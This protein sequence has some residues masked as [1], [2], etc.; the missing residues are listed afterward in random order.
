MYR[1]SPHRRSS[2]DERHAPVVVSR[3]RR[4]G[5]WGTTSSTSPNHN[6][7]VIVVAVVVVIVIAYAAMTSCRSRLPTPPPGLRCRSPR[8]L[9]AVREQLCQATPKVEHKGVLVGGANREKTASARTQ[10][11]GCCSRHAMGGRL[12]SRGGPIERRSL[13]P[14]EKRR[15]RTDDRAAGTETNS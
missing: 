1:V 12:Q 2:G 6:I 3:D 14:P 4:K 8:W 11:E 9:A 13:E 7:I 5:S 15:Q 10:S